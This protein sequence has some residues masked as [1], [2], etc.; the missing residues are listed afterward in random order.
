MDSDEV[1]TKKATSQELQYTSVTYWYPIYKSQS[2]RSEILPLGDDFVKY[3][4]ISDEWNNYNE[5][6]DP[7]AECP[8]FIELQEKMKEVIDEMGAVFP[9]TN[10][11]SPRDSQW[12]LK[13]PSL[14]CISVEDVF[15]LLKASTRLSYE[16]DEWLNQSQ[17]QPAVILRKWYE[18][19]PSMEFRCFVVEGSLVAIS[20]KNCR[21]K[22]SHLLEQKL[23]LKE[24]IFD[25]WKSHIQSSFPLLEYTFDVYLQ[26]KKVITNKIY[27]VFLVSFGVFG[28]E[29]ESPCLYEWS[30]FQHFKNSELDIRF[31][32]NDNARL[33]PSDNIYNSIPA[34]LQTANTEELTSA[35]KICREQIEKEDLDS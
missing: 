29:D 9:R 28:L 25:F 7:E 22:Y 10:W 1:S 33:L 23:I 2:L 3:H 20:Q 16:F 5:E 13:T 35:I 24:H 26:K 34:D 18:M 8:D 15:M 21:E 19:E 6:E 17:V 12:I 31:V 11:S 30:D 32:E 27:R 14:K 4:T